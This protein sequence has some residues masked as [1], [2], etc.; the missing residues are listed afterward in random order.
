[1]FRIVMFVG[2]RFRADPAFFYPPI[3]FETAHRSVVL[4]IRG[5]ADPSS[6]DLPLLVPRHM[7]VLR[8]YTAR[9]SPRQ[10]RRTSGN[11]THTGWSELIKLT[12]LLQGLEGQSRNKTDRPA[13][14]VFYRQLFYLVI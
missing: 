14:L 10:S 11:T 4:S 1:M 2:S 5:S 8:L 13:R 6:T 7:Q 3:I 12:P 9:P